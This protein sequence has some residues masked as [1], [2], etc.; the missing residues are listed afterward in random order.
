L[1]DGWTRNCALLRG[2]AVA[3]VFVALRQTILACDIPMSRF[4]ICSWRFAK[5]RPCIVTPAWNGVL[6]TAAIRRIRLGAW[7]YTFVGI[8]MPSGSTFQMRL[9]GVAASE[10]LA[11]CWPRPGQGRIYIPLEALAAHGLTEDDI[12][13]RRFDARYVALMKDLVSRTRVLFN[14]GLPLAG[15]VEGKLRIDLEMFSRGGMAVLGA[16]ESSGYIRCITVP[17]SAK[18]NK[19]PCWAVLS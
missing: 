18:Q 12:V 2:P 3:S 4:P 19:P 10:F 7:C 5:T 13:V 11:G 6:A 16:I 15:F 14:K 9:H 17:L 1:L 8:A